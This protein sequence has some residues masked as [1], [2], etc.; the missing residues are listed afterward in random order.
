MRPPSARC[1]VKAAGTVFRTRCTTVRHAT[2]LCSTTTSS[3]CSRSSIHASRSSTSCGSW[4]RAP[5]QRTSGSPLTSERGSPNSFRRQ[6]SAGVSMRSIGRSSISRRSPCTPGAQGSR[7]CSSAS[8]RCPTPRRC[9]TACFH[10]VR[11]VWAMQSSSRGSRGYAES[12]SISTREP[13]T[14]SR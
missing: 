1:S 3:P 7:D 9:S 5:W 13:G 8:H 2:T 10:A 12:F 11:Q 14:P 6:E 4:M